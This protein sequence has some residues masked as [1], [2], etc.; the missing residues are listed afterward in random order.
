[1]PQA[2]QHVATARHAAALHYCS[3]ASRT[4][5]PSYLK[6]AMLNNVHTVTT[7]AAPLLLL[8]LLLQP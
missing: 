3:L 1:M 4:R 8:L 2:L 5:L 7:A 6:P